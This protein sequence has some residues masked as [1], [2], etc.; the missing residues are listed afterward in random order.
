M[1]T[2]NRGSN[3]GSTSAVMWFRRDLRVRDNPALLAALDE[4]SVTALFVVDPAALGHGGPG[5]QGVAGRQRARARRPD[6]ADHP[7]RRPRARSCR[8]WPTARRVHVAAETTP[9]GRRRDD[10]RGRAGRARRD[11][12]AV[13][14]GARAGPQR[15]RR[16]PT[17]C[18]A[19]S[20]APGASTAGPSPPARPAPPTSSRPT[21]TRRTGP[22]GGGGRRG[23][24]RAA[25]RRRG[26]RLAPLALLPRR[27]PARLRGRAQPPRPRRHLAALALPPPRGAPPALAPRR[28]PP[29]VDVRR[30]SWRGAT[31]TPTCCWHAPSSAWS[32]LKPALEGMRYDDPED[33]IEAWRTGTTGYPIV[34]AG[35]RQLMQPGGCTTGC[36]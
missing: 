31:S 27:R 7:P 13:R 16:R 17:R 35:M 10:G 23:A 32:D 3:R 8:R 25:R 22:A 24:V 21:P 29:H 4:G 1:S 34:D 30:P 33:A 11:R 36:G 14:R 9:Y 5:P 28:G 20:P 15:Q 19:P 12:V 26:R 18:S 6:P 2:P